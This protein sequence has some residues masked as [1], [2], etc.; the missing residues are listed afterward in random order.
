MPETQTTD[1]W[2]NRLSPGVKAALTV[3][4]VVIMLEVVSDLLPAVGFVV[5]LPFAIATYYVQGLLAGRYLK[6]DPRY[7]AA[8]LGRYLGAGAL[9]AFWTGV[10][11][12]NVV[13][14]ID[15]VLLTPVT[16]GAVLAALPLVLV[17]SLVDIA[18]NFFFTVLGAWLYRRFSG[19]RL[20][21]IS[22]AVMGLVMAGLCL[23]GAALAGGLIFGGVDLFKHLPAIL[24]T[25]T[26]V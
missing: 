9:S 23:V 17:S 21:G 25:P 10:V 12:S 24:A 4:V 15:T 8:G 19:G 16:L 20:F 1:S 26:P 3:A 6:N 14:I 2:W 22:C 5:A 13:T 7:P 11:I 18:L